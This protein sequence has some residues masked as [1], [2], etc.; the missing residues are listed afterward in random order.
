MNMTTTPITAL[1]PVP[2]LPDFEQ[3]QTVLRRGKPDRPTLFEFFLND[4][5]YR[6]LAGLPEQARVTPFVVAEAFRRAGYDYVTFLPPGL[7]FPQ[8]E[9][10]RL[11]THSLNEGGMISDRASFEAYPWP[12]PDQADYD[13]I[14]A[15]GRALPSGMRIVIHGPGGVL[16]NAVAIVGFETLCCLLADD[17]ELASEV[18]AAIGSRLLRFYERCLEYPAVGAIIGNDDWG[19][20][21]QPMLSPMD[22]RRYVFPW[23]RQ[24][25]AAAHAAGRPAILHSCGNAKEIMDDIID[26]LRY[27]AKHS[28]EDA[29]QPVE[30]AY[31]QYGARIAVLGGID[32]DFVIRSPPDAVYTRA[33]RMLERAE[34][35]GGYA[36]GTGNSVPAY[37]PDEQ[38]FALIRAALDRR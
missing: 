9:H 21:T 8:R 13:W 24:I 2:D 35:R 14:E 22:L 3:L 18:F 19:F 30:E 7:S 10:A 31:D 1:R 28:Y 25:V 37:V 23:H 16:E 33:V 5:L 34:T 12:D 15:L 11:A 17:P 20:K 32:V 26:D 36:L 6:R 38:Y 4:R 29:I 27:D